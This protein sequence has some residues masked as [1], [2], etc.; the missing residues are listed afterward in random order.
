MIFFQN[1]NGNEIF[2]QTSLNFENGLFQLLRVIKDGQVW[3]SNEPGQEIKL[4]GIFAQSDQQ[5]QN[6]NSLMFSS[7]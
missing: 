5:N 6:Q 7:V 4:F 1:Y 2:H 3:L